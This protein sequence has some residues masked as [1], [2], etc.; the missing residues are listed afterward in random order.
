M[1]AVIAD[2]MTGAAELAAIGTRYGLRAI[3]CD[4]QVHREPADLLVVCSDSRSAS[5]EEAMRITREIAE[6]IRELQPQLLYKKTDS[7]LRGYVMEEIR[8]LE[9]VFQKTQVLLVPANP[10]LGRTIRNG[11]YYIDDTLINQTSFAT[12]PEFPVQSADVLKMLRAPGNTVVLQAQKNLPGSG[13]YLG[14]AA[15][16]QDLDGWAAQLTTNTLPAGGAEFFNAILQHIFGH[17][18]P[19]DG[20]PPWKAPLLWVCGTAFR[21]SIAH[22]EGLRDE[23]GLHLEWLA[24]GSMHMDAKAM[25][26]LVHTIDEDGK[27]GLA[28]SQ[29]GGRKDGQAKLLR[30]QMAETV[31]EIIEKAAVRELI[32]EGGSTASSILAA[33]NISILTPV[34]ELAEG[35]VRMHT[36]EEFPEYI[37]IK[38]GSYRWPPTLPSLI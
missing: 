34:E 7:V 25:Q 37:T 35:V 1:I 21:E 13:E 36:K 5:Y 18:R 6:A 27:A 16:L 3:I 31:R 38:P 32:I 17:T 30:E 22:L 2:D 9:D 28:I 14:E 10:G 29:E 19:L 24:P 11:Q 33:L 4:R 15:S 23:K 12:D 26:A 8:I 20:L